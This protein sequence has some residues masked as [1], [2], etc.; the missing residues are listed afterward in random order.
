MVV[1]IGTN[2][3]RGADGRPDP[4]FLQGIADQVAALQRQGYQ[5]V[6]VSSGA[7]GAG[8][9][10]LGLTGR[11]QDVKLRQ[12]CAA[13][14]QPQLMNGWQRAFDAHEV[15]VAQL[16]LTHQTF[17]RRASFLNLRNTTDELLERGVVPIAN[18]NDTVSIEEIDASFGD[19]DRL[20][21]MIASKIDADLLVLLTD[22]DGMYTKPPGR[23]GSTRIPVIERVEAKHYEMAAYR[24][25]SAGGRGGMRNKLDAA[26][27]ACRR[28][29]QV[30]LARGRDEDVLG[31]IVKGQ[32]V[33]TRFLPQ[34]REA[35]KDAWLRMAHPAGVVHIDEGAAAALRNGKHLLPA[36][37]T[38]VE[39]DF[40]A[41]DVVE[42]RC[43][44]KAVARAL[45]GLSRRDLEA[46]MGVKS[47]DAATRLGRRGPFN[48]TRKDN[49]VLV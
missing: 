41:R 37:V 36:G 38:R 33:G 17:T 19:N 30:V 2:T 31:R 45:T 43:G 8:Q 12:A 46:V 18:E 4:A 9:A 40:H 1:K 26:A 15:R 5:L 16:L 42:I 24:P 29:I 11:L 7:I 21:A 39:G 3:L 48:V 23:A 13:I 14:G 34:G 25:G 10:T 32:S 35:S 6:L 28:G 27:F 22:V 49:L 44:G 47:A 20:S